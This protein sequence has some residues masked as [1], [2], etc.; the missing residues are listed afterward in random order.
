MSHKASIS[1]V[2]KLG[3]NHD[4]LVRKWQN[5]LTNRLSVINVN[6]L[7]KLMITIV[8]ILQSN[9]FVAEL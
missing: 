1:L 9:S 7:T 5:E 8:N 2:S 6:C 3:L 4:Q